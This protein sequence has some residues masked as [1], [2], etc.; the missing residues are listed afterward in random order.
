M[1]DCGASCLSLFSRHCSR[2]APSVIGGLLYCHIEGVTAQ[3][4]LLYDMPLAEPVPML[5]ACFSPCFIRLSSTRRWEGG[6]PS[7]KGD[8]LVRAVYKISIDR[9]SYC[10][11]SKMYVH[12]Y[13]MTF[14][15][16]QLL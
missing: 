11:V 4:S 8:F 2:Q 5:K 15:F 7:I 14:S 10:F 16:P 1:H 12:V 9:L 13:F 3:C 6:F